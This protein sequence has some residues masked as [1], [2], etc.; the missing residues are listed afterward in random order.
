MENKSKE[1]QALHKLNENMY[2]LM[3]ALKVVISNVS[4]LTEIIYNKEISKIDNE[5]KNINNIENI[6]LHSHM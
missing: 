3:D 6:K 1:I 5:I 4:E 2:V